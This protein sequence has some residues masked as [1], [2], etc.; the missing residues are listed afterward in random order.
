MPRGSDVYKNPWLKAEDLQDDDEIFTIVGSDIHTFKETDGKERSQIVLSLAETE[1]KLGLNVTN[2]TVLKDIFKSE[3]S[4][5]WHGCKIVL[6][7][8]QTS[9]QD[10]RQVDCLRIKKKTTEKLFLERCDRETKRQNDRFPKDPANKSK[11][12]A[13][14]ITQQEADESAYPPF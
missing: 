14:P 9:M 5:D 6:F 2:Y 12:P 11:K 7:V 1:K 3:E 13:E 10:G 4:E 8:T